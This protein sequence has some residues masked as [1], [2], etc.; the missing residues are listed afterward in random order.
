MRTAQ[1]SLPRD[2][3]T[4][5]DAEHSYAAPFDRHDWIIDRCGT[6]VRYIIDFYSGAPASDLAGAATAAGGGGA[7]ARSPISFYLDVRPAP[8]LEGIKMRA[9][10]LF[11]RP[12]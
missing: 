11:L 1:R 7:P 8:D 6:R 3:T 5:A 2:A 9:H 10:R 12:N 4:P